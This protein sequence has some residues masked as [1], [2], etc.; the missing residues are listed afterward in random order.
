MAEI[1]L[2]YKTEDRKRVAH[3]VAAMRAAGLDIWWDQDIPPGG[4]WRHT[5]A[6]QLDEATLCVVAWSH[7]STGPRGRFVLEEAERTA[8]RGAYLGVLIDPVQ[9]PFGFAEWQSIDLSD[10]DGKA[11][12]P[13]LDHFVAQVR[14]R[15]E[16]KP[17]E[18]PPAS[19][20]RRRLPVKPLAIGLGVL[21]LAAA[22]LLVYRLLPG[23]AAPAPTPTAFVNAKLGQAACSWL[24]ISNVTSAEGGER[25]ALAGIAASPPAVQAALMREAMQAQVPI[26][27]IG[28]EDVATGPSET[29]AQLELMR[30]YRWTGRTHLTTIP[31]RG[32]FVQT[33][34]GWRGR[35]EF[36][37]D[38]RDL[39]ANS[40]LLALDS[41]GGIEVLA[42][43]LQQYRRTQ[44]ALRSRGEVVAYE[45]YYFDENQ[46]ARN[47]GLILM[48]ASAPIDAALV[49]QIGEHGDRAFQRR[50]AEAAAAQHWQFELGLVRC[51]FEGGQRRGC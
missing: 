43:N 32:A 21:L 6:A 31:S 22:A 8:G 41:V 30:Q 15:L 36:E 14:A 49:A 25:I 11:K 38:Y 29:C 26:A 10:W 44:P 20:R 42:P 45:S 1:F 19:A 12:G 17:I 27:E 18:A 47:V 51:G 37:I 34:D 46:S 5:I 24:Q 13:L 48:T 16:H 40:A 28:V 35:L 23:P 50:I 9:P 3:L 39:P 4:G 7:E 33:P 2:S